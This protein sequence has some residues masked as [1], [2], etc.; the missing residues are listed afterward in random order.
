MK[1]IINKYIENKDIFFYFKARIALFS[2]LQAFDIKENDEIIVSAYTCVVVANPII[3][4]KAKPVYVDINPNTYNMD[5]T[6]IEKKITSKTKAIILQNT[7]GLSSDIEEIIKIAKKYKIYTVEDCCHGF[8]GKYN[9]K[10]NG[11]Y[12]DAAFFSTQWN[13]PFSTG[14]GGFAVIN[15]KKLLSKIKK[16]ESKKIKP[17]LKDI[18]SLKLLYLV[19][20]FILKDNTYWMLLKLYR[21]LSK[22]N[23]I[24]GSSQGIEISST[25]IPKDFF[26]DFSNTQ[27][28][29]GVK[30]LKK[31]DDILK[32]R[33]ENARILYRFFKEKS[34]K[35]C[36]EKII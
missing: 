1:N 4:L 9:D 8:G 17:T 2:I 15:N 16:L 28:Q 34:Q 14:L 31:F 27:M 7:Y 36:C 32:L 22:K 5:Y 35:I 29:E 3:Y 33:K 6:K 11:T 18:V 25:K 13:K 24:L 21:F 19:K 12:C 30:N 23:L 20:R 26:K 10:P